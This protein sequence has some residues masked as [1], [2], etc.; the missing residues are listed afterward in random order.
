MTACLRFEK[1]LTIFRIW[2]N[3]RCMFSSRRRVRRPELLPR[4][5]PASSQLSL[6]NNS[7]AIVAKRSELWRR[8]FVNHQS[9][10]RQSLLQRHAARLHTENPDATIPFV[11][12]FVA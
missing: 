3:L 8:F 4:E 2:P 5:Q 7:P 1:R 11:R 10:S 9:S 12:G 6:K